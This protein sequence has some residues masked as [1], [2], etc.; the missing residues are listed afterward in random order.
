MRTGDEGARGAEGGTRGA[1][2]GTI[3]ELLEEAQRHV[4]WQREEMERMAEDSERCGG[5]SSCCCVALGTIMTSPFLSRI[6]TGLVEEVRRLRQRGHSPA[7]P[8]PFDEPERAEGPV[9]ENGSSRNPF[10]E[11]EAGPSPGGA[12]AEGG[13][14]GGTERGEDN[15]RRGKPRRKKSTTFTASPW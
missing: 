5:G 10:D 12:V 9:R 14:V 15:S 6:I 8:N 2:G 13:R 11:L 7:T 4:A 1:G 3:E